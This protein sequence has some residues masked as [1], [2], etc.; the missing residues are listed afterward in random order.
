MICFNAIT[1]FGTL[2]DLTQLLKYKS[3]TL[4]TR[5]L[6]VVSRTKKPKQFRAKIQPFNRARHWYV[7]HSAQVQNAIQQ[8]LLTIPI[9]IIV[10]FSH[11]SIHSFIHSF[12]SYLKIHTH[13]QN[14]ANKHIAP[15]SAFLYLLTNYDD[16]NTHKN[17]RPLTSIEFLFSHLHRAAPGPANHPR[18]VHIHIPICACIFV[19][20]KLAWTFSAAC[21]RDKAI[22]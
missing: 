1:C 2:K 16:K 18:S 4:L 21:S 14:Y 7:L 8:P 15:L 11:N 20:E 6:Q 22:W 9:I 13:T 5:Q 12:L 17:S 19:H 10:T 3:N